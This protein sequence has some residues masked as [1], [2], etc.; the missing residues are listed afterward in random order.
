MSGF[1]VLLAQLEV[2]KAWF[3]FGLKFPANRWSMSLVLIQRSISRKNKFSRIT[4]SREKVGVIRIVSIDTTCI[5]VFTHDLR[6]ERRSE[7]SSCIDTV[8]FIHPPSPPLDIIVAR[9]SSQK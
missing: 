3:V 7:V 6:E 5:I 9:C 2:F 4:I 1:E 8:L